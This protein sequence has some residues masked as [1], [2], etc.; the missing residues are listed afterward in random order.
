MA[1]IAVPTIDF[2]PFLKGGAAD[3]AAVARAIDVACT[4]I[5]F[6]AITG[7][8]VA[9]HAIEE[10]RAAAVNFFAQPDADKALVA[11]PA[12]RI[13]RGWNFVGDRSLAYSLGHETPPDLQESFAMGPVGVPD[14]PYFSCDRARAF[15]A[16]NLWPDA[17]PEL[18]VM[19]TDYFRVMGSLAHAV[20]QAFALALGQPQTHFDHMIDRHTSSLRLVRYPG[21]VEALADQRRAGAHTDYGSLTILRGDNLPGGLQVKLRHGDWTD[22]TRP[23]GGFVCNIGDAMARWTN[24]RWVSTLHRVGLPPAGQMAEDRISIVFFHNPNYDAEM[25]CITADGETAKYP[26]ETFDAY[27]I[28]KLNR[29]SFG[30]GGAAEGHGS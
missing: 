26:D 30:K 13:S 24:D 12:D 15:F 10:L 9:E 21:Q 27:F 5:G 29:G 22:I 23:E 8:G 17:Q 20:M 11:R 1:E 28:D 19:M 7:H 18:R 2:E 3:R 25:S 14:A 16:P 6:F 4:E